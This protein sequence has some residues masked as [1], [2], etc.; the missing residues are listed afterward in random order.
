LS[1]IKRFVTDPQGGGFCELDLDGGQRIKVSHQK[2]ASRAG[3]LTIDVL[4]FTGISADRIFVVNLDSPEGKAAM[5]R[6]TCDVLPPE[7]ILA[8]PVGAFVGYVKDCWSVEEVQAKCRA[9]MGTS[10]PGRWLHGI[11]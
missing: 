7:N 6:L 4:K 8:T 9:L 2:M 11:P 10:T 5:A 1:T 3:W